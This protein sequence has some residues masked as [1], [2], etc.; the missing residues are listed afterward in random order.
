ML[1]IIYNPTSG[2]NRGARVQEA[3]KNQLESN[4]I[5]HT[6]WATQKKGDAQSFALQLT[7]QGET[8]IVS[9]GGDGTLHEVL[10]GI[11]DPSKVHLG[12]IPC[13]SGNDFASAIGIPKQPMDALKLILESS[14]KPTDYLEC[15]GVR[16]INILGAGIDVDIL[17]RS[18][19]AKMLRGS[20]NYFV[21]LIN[22]LIHF[23]NCDMDLEI[24]G[25][26]TRHSGFIVC[27]CN[28]RRFGGG[29]E[30]CPDA[31]VD[32]GLI[33][34][35]LVNG[36]PRRKYIS[37]V[38]ALARRRLLE[39]PYTIHERVQSVRAAFPKPTTLQ[40]DGELYD[41]LPFDVRVVHDKLRVYR[42]GV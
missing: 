28:G 33:D 7:E 27:A 32:D 39:Q 8:D 38:L 36:L 26:T 4:G 34:V 29:I 20:L 41:D 9:M 5:Q 42:S 13:G 37:A 16:C 30:I 10:N 18:Y 40:L 15:S 19:R 17:R 35:V 31:I 11:Y 21:S 14:P 24:R 12:I 22:A 25:Q 23:E 3:L 2:R 6:F 1:H